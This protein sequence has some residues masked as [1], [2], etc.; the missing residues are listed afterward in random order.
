MVNPANLTFNS[1]YTKYYARFV[2]FA[3]TYVRST[4]VAEDFT[5]EAFMAYWDNKDNL[6]PG[7]NIK[8]Y[9]LTVIKNKCLNYLKQEERRRIIVTGISDYAQWELDLRISSLE[10]CDPDEIFSEEIQR[11]VN[12][13]LAKLP[14]QTLD[15]FVL[16]RYK[17]K[18]HKEIAEMFNITPKGVEYHISKALSVLRL[19]LKDYLPAWIALFFIL[20]K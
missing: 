10:A 16:S 18:S 1:F 20:N 13:T 5:T 14:K 2:R 6:A 8:A 19:N 11:I 15:I 7:S 4:D 3:H 12:E 9:I 17:E